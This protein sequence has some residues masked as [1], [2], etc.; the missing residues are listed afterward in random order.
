MSQGNEK[1]MQYY[2]IK[3][4]M[5]QGAFS[6]IYASFLS[7]F[8]TERNISISPANTLSGSLVSTPLLR[9]M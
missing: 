7:V 5:Q 9:P 1:S 4:P 6:E 3:T 2:G 8:S